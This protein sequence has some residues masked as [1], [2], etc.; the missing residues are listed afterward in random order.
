MSLLSNSDCHVI[1]STH[2]FF[3][4]FHALTGHVLKNG[5]LSLHSFVPLL[6][7]QRSSWDQRG[8]QHAQFLVGHQKR[9]L[10]CECGEGAVRTQQ[11][12]SRSDHG[13]VVHR[14]AYTVC[15][16]NYMHVRSAGCAD[17]GSYIIVRYRPDNLP[18]AQVFNGL[19]VDQPAGSVANERHSQ[20]YVCTLT[21]LY[22]PAHMYRY[23][24]NGREHEDT[25]LHR[26]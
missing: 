6:R 25:H 11:R 1:R 22:T 12:P 10:G 16:Y 17:Q 26:W 20:Q 18:D 15:A 2:Y 24:C 8:F 19:P 9:R 23:W 4:R 13:T 21:I 3:A 14:Y 5:V 7:L